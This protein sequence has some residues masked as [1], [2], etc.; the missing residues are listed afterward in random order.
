MST[1]SCKVILG[2]NA[3]YFNKEGVVHESSVAL[4]K[5]G[6][7]VAAIAEERLSRKKGDG[8]YP[9]LAIDEVLKITN[10]KIGEVEK[11]VI[12]N[13][14]PTQ[15]S[16][17]YLKSLFSTFF[18]T[19]VFLGKQI[20]TFSWYW[21][22]NKFKTPQKVNFE[23]KGKVYPILVEF[24]NHHTGHAAS[25]YYA[26]P[27]DDAL[28][29]TID[30][31]GDGLDGTVFVGEGT[32]MHKLINIP[33]HQSPGTMYSAITNDLGFRRLRHEGK[34]TGLAAFGNPD[35]KRLGLENL[36]R[37][38]SK[39]HRFISKQIAKHHVDLQSKSE[40]FFPLLQKYSKEDLAASTQ[41]IFEDVII[42]FIKDAVTVA[43]KKGYKTANI[44]LAGGCFT[45][46]KLNQHIIETG[47][48]DNIFIYPAMGDE[49]LAAG[50]ALN[51]YYN[52]NQLNDKHN[53]VIDNV[54]LGGEFSDSEIEHALKE[55]SLTYERHEDVEVVLGKL[56]ADGKIIGRYN[57]RM[58]YG[59]RALGN[60]SIIGA[61]FDHKINDWLNDKLNRTEFMPFAPSVL[62]ENAADYFEGYK[63]NQIAADFMTITY[64]VKPGMKEKIP[65]VVH[66][67]NTARPQIV[68]KAT[69]PS[70]H[71]IIS[72]FFK[73]SG[74]AVVL[75]TSFNIHEEPI[76]YTP[77][78]AIRGFLYS[79]LD[80]LALGNYVVAFE[81]NR[82]RKS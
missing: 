6:K 9:H 2:I 17:E 74:C 29:V 44:C 66:V 18:D 34:I 78:D 35:Y 11:V 12:S 76:V 16:Y 25:A 71:K 36:I 45:N 38:D 54:Y 42:E 21:I 32:K 4:L 8:R 23:Y 48:F 37:Y 50:A 43:N 13:L 28:V 79:E 77:Q 7:I 57:G 20:K 3:N 33:H 26:S 39:K 70:Y 30:G 58:E 51:S 14:H 69:N 59:P 62:E 41:A 61:P 63:S 27:F 15:N 53:S 64:N 49:G 67:D 81:K 46:V 60:R 56:L 73:H 40:Y 72:E 22:Y 82:H 10:T 19:G 75:N 65:A 24:S 80:Y 31:G 52:S 5:N 1:N 55:F 68:R 47:L